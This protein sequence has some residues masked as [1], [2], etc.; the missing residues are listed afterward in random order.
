MYMRVAELTTRSDLLT[1]GKL[2]TPIP[3]NNNLSRRQAL[4]AWSDTIQ[5][6][7]SP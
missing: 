7:E 2:M 5:G 4:P 6:K 1:Q 3:K